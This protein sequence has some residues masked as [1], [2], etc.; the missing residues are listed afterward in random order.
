MRIAAY[1]CRALSGDI[2]A[3][4]NR[5]DWAARGAAILG[6]DV[7]VL[8][9][10]YL[11]GYAV[12][13]ALDS[14]A[15]C[16]QSPVFDQIGAVARTHRIALALGY[17]ERRQEG[18]HNMA[19]L[20]DNTGKLLLQYSKTHLFGADEWRRF[21]PGRSVSMA[22]L[23][24][25]PTGL[26]ICYDME[27]PEP[28]RLLAENGARLV[29]APTANMHPYDSVSH[30]LVPARAAENAITVAYV[31]Y[32]G[33]EGALT[34]CGQSA[35]IGPDGD[36]LARAG[37]SEEALLIAE[38]PTARPNLS[39]QLH[40]RRTIGFTPAPPLRPQASP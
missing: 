15:L 8:P 11:T 39:T 13:D 2:A 24:G 9:E 19:G 35:I 38:I 14:L 32:V 4:L 23:A 3:N 25:M 7:L 34:Y 31:N 21:A 28:A 10:L 17:P 12:G 29:L 18:L 5:L 27:F 36:D 33:C 6:A 37:R 40:D 20:W 26:L 22:D 16:P 30:R 1:Q